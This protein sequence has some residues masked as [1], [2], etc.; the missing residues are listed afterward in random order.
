MQKN[1]TMK[2]TKEENDALM[3]MAYYVAGQFLRG[4]QKVDSKM[5]LAIDSAALEMKE[6]AKKRKSADK[7]N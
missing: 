7:N 5:S 2:L 3:K 4:G 1:N 6:M